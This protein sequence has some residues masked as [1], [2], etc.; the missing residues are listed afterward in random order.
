[1]HSVNPGSH[2]QAKAATE[3]IR[4][5]IA[6]KVPNLV[7]ETVRNHQQILQRSGLGMRWVRPEN[8]HLTMR[9]FGDVNRSA[10]GEI[11]AAMTAA[12]QTVSPFYLQV[13]ELGVFPNLKRPRVLWLGIRDP[14]DR[15][16]TLHD[17]LSL[18]LTSRG[19]PQEKR[20]FAGHVT[21]GRV[22]GRLNLERLSETVM[23][24]SDL[25]GKA[26]LV[27]EIYLMQSELKPTGAVYKCLETSPFPEQ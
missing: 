20:R 7:R 23:Q 24:S 5:F 11:H 9:F 13:H 4:A 16:V 27:E 8:I 14:V 6:I 19:F 21:I 12:V 1:M 25:P 22:K 2:F 10:L 15:L 17:A 26:F 18:E 3:T